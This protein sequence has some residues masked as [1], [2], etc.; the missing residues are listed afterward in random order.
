M[1]TDTLNM[2]RKDEDQSSFK[3]AAVLLSESAG[4][5]G[6][7]LSGRLASRERFGDVRPRP[8]DGTGA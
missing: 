3:A 1:L 8:R 4:S 7:E 2:K 6:K 5:I